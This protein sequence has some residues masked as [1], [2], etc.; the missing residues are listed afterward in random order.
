ML[1]THSNLMSLD[2]IYVAPRLRDATDDLPHPRVVAIGIPY[3]LVTNRFVFQ[4]KSKDY[5]ARCLACE[6]EIH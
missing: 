3:L 5:I 4:V 6:T 2:P 1:A